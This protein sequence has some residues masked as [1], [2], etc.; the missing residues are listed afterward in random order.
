MSKR[1][2]ICAIALLGTTAALHAAGVVDHVVIAGENSI[3][4]TWRFGDRAFPVRGAR[5]GPGESV[6]F[7]VTPKTGRQLTLE[8]REFRTAAGQY[9]AY[10][11]AANGKDIAF[12]CRQIDEA[13]RAS[14]FIDLPDAAG[15]VGIRIRNLAD[16]VLCLSGAYLYEDIET[17]AREAGLMRPLLLGPTVRA[18]SRERLAAVKALI[19]ASPEI[20]PLVVDA[21]FAIAQ[22][23]PEVT[24]RRLA[25]V[26][27]AATEAGVAVTLHL[28]TWWAGTPFGFDGLG[29]RWCDPEYQQVT[30]EPVTG[31][32][33][34]SIPNQWSSVPWL[35]TR[36]ARLNS[37][38]AGC[39]RTFGQL[40]RAEKTAFEARHGKPSGKAFPIRTI[41]LDNEITYWGAGNPGMSSTLQADFN[42]AIVAAARGRDVA[43][44]PRDGLAKPEMRFLRHS[45]R[46]YNRE[47][48]VGLLEGLGTCPLSDRVYTHT[49]MRGWCFDNA[50]QATEVGVLDTIRMGGEWGEVSTHGL[51][52]LDVHRELGV[53]VDIN[54]ELGGAKD[55]IGVANL[56]YAAGCSELDL[57]NLS[58]DGVRAT[59]AGIGEGW[60][61][62][63]PEPWR[64]AVFHEDFEQPGSWRKR[65]SGEGIRIDGIGERRGLIGTKVKTASFAR[66]TVTAREL[67]DAPVFDRLCLNL[68]A[69][70]FLFRQVSADSYLAIRVGPDA[71]SLT[72][73]ARFTNMAGRRRVDLTDHVRGQAGALIEFELHPL[74]LPGWVAVF[75][76][77]LEVPW[78]AEALLATNRS[79]RADRL[80]AESVIVAQRAEAAHPLRRRAPV[81]KPYVPPAP[82]REEAGE[83]RGPV[84][85]TIVI[86]PYE[87][88]FMNWRLPVAEGCRIALDDNGVTKDV[89]GSAIV[90]GDDVVITLRDGKATEIRAR[91]RSARGR[92]IAFEPATPFQ[93]PLLHIE[94][95][96]ILPID[97]RTTVRGRITDRKP[98]ACPLVVGSRDFKPGDVVAIR[99]NPTR[100]RI[101]AAELE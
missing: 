89:P 35:T 93:L 20:A 28:N 100:G 79:Y 57:F 21:T 11:I 18:F 17:Y 16:H 19:P 86:D 73:V 2:S 42:P 22:W 58:D 40:V 36:H 4:Y 55:A 39:F 92:V 43:L 14:A 29:G 65:F 37:F 62:F 61:S 88:G 83:A 44:D 12:R 34:L 71:D 60:Q 33:G 8:L 76:V 78:A 54:C 3:E 64:P 96:T 63:A 31:Q 24:Q 82:D 23:P 26:I 66:F 67:V 68:D 38:K 52:M 13:G 32:F 81:D 70:A 6:S 1:A 59:V 97:S 27:A 56:A 80:R 30:F 47:M 101:V 5:L 75:E 90:G 25:N 94:G 87:G 9:P 51:S 98:A 41:V 49:F 99:W 15:P 69:R 77:T 85:T 84:G 53:P 48:A 74:G 95:A 10:I 91:R 72:E 7:R 45:L 46:Q 50:I